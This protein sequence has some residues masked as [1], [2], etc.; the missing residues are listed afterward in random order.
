MNQSILP[1]SR[2]PY[3]FDPEPHADIQHKLANDVE[4]LYGRVKDLRD[5]EL[6]DVW[7]LSRD[8]VLAIEKWSEPLLAFE[9]ARKMDIALEVAWAF[10]EK[11]G[12]VDAIRDKVST[13]VPFLPGFMSRWLLGRL[14]N[15]TV[16][17]RMVQFVLELAVRE[18]KKL[19]GRGEQE[20]AD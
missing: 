12:G 4:H 7:L 20:Q 17:K 19:T 11:R 6:T 16:A 14:L 1:L 10:A 5:M 9:G 2:R 3:L 13:A 8:L 18:M 15:K